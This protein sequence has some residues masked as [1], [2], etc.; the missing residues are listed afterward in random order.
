MRGRADASGVMMLP[1]DDDDD[2][3]GKWVVSCTTMWT[4]GGAVLMKQRCDD[5]KPCSSISFL[6]APDDDDRLLR[7]EV[8]KNG[9]E[10]VFV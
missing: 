2:D 5:T 3:D 1:D 9:N 10:V 8:Q 6:K 7:Q 4:L